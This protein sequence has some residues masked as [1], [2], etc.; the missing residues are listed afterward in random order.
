MLRDGVELAST[1]KLMVLGEQMHRGLASAERAANMPA[2]RS[3]HLESE[4]YERCGRL[5]C[6][7]VW[8]SVFWLSFNLF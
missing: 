5:P 2:W 7:Y 4:R 3:E 1:L 6:V 8:V